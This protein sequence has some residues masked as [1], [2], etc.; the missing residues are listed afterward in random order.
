MAFSPVDHLLASSGDDGSVLRRVAFLEDGKRIASS[1]LD[2]TIR[3]W[4]LADR[5][6]D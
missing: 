2:H 4:D 5:A 3:L 1:S 6:A